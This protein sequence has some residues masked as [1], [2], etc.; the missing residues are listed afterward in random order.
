MNDHKHFRESQKSSREGLLRLLFYLQGIRVIRQRK[1]GAD[2]L[3]YIVC[4]QRIAVADDTDYIVLP[5]LNSDHFFCV[6][7]DFHF[8]NHVQKIIDRFSLQH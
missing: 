4:Y 2:L 1:I 8:V 3:F 6:F 5:F 7:D